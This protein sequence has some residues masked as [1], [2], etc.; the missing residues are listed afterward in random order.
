MKRLLKFSLIA[1]II[2][3]VAA[4]FGIYT[5]TTSYLEVTFHVFFFV[6]M[7]LVIASLSAL[8]FI[9]EYYFS[10]YAKSMI[11]PASYCIV[12]LLIFS[13]Y[14]LF[15]AAGDGRTFGIIGALIY[16]GLIFVFVA[17]VNLII[18]IVANLKD[19]SKTSKLK[20][21]RNK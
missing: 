14:Y 11:I 19:K 3:V 8:Y 4:A 20:H 18:F 16:S 5:E 2:S 6:L 10:S 9:E 21:L 15:F 13:T 7:P 12:S 17:I 1:I